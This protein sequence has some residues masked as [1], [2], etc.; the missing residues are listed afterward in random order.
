M[1]NCIRQPQVNSGL[2]DPVFT[3]KQIF[4][5]TELVAPARSNMVNK[6][7]VDLL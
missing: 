4:I 1:T 5:R 2:T 3:A 6:G 7:F